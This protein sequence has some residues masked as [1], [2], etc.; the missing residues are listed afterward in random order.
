MSENT[1]V[2][3]SH[4]DVE[5]YDNWMFIFVFLLNI[6]TSQLADIII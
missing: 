4:S 6:Q 2:I 5:I 3:R 1:N